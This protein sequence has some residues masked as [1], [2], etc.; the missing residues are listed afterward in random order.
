MVNKENGEFRKVDSFESHGSAPFNLTTSFTV[1]TNDNHSYKEANQLS[2]ANILFA[3][4]CFSNNY[5]NR[6][7]HFLEISNSNCMYLG[8]KKIGL[9]YA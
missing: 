4:Y 7:L 8:H 1:T 9:D 5:Y 3:A 6:G 2:K